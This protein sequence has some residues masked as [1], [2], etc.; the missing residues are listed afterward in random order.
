[1]KLFTR[2]GYAGVEKQF[3]DRLDDAEQSRFKGSFDDDFY[4][5][6]IGASY[7]FSDRFYARVDATA[8]SIAAS[9]GN[10]LTIGAGVRV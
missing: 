6:G 5:V 10:T 3:D 8:Y 2:F 4:A 7:D 1:L 9:K